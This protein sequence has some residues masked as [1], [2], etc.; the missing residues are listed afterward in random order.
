VWL[1][2]YYEEKTSIEDMGTFERIT[3]RQYCAMQENG[4]PRAIL[5]MCELTIKK[6]ENLLLLRAKSCI[7]VLGNHKDRIW[8]KPQRYASVLLSESLRF[9]VSMAVEQRR[10]LKQGN[11][12]NAF[13]NGNL[14]PEEVTVVRPPLGDPSAAKNEFWLLKK[15]VYGLRC[16]PKHWYDKIDRIFQSMG[17]QKNI[18]DPCL[19]TGFIKDPEDPSNTAALIPMALGSTLTILY[20]SPRVTRSRPNSKQYYSASS[21]LISWASFNG[22]AAYI[23]LGAYH[24]VKSTST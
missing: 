12:K 2:S 7:V 9:L 3:L 23:F 20:S 8:T 5:T 1:Q 16:S 17:I 24:R 4:C 13:C 14:P 22:S 18:Y 11:V 21:L 6:D 10:T 15:T 19:Y